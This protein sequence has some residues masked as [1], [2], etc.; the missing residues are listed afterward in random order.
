MAQSVTASIIEDFRRARFKADLQNILSRLTGQNNELLVYD[1][2]RQKLRGVETATRRHEAI[3]LDAIVGSVG[4]YGDYNRMFLP[5]KDSDADR[6]V[7]VKQAVTGLAGVPPIEVYKIGEAY[8]VKDGNHRVSVAR[9]LG[10]KT[11]DAY[12][13]DVQTDVPFSLH[14]TPDD[15]ITK[16]EYADFLE[17]TG[18]NKLRPEA[19]LSVTVPG[20]Y[21]TLL[22]H[23]QVHHYFM[24]LEA[25]RDVSYEEAV[26]HWYDTVYRPIAQ[27][28]EQ[29][30]LL[31]DFPHRTATDLYLWLAEHQAELERELG[32]QLSPAKVTQGVSEVRQR[33]PRETRLQELSPEKYLLDSVLVAIN[34]TEGGWRAL[35]QAF[36]LARREPLRLYGLHVVAHEGELPAAAEVQAEF[37]RR[38]QQAGVSAQF[39]TEVG[40]VTSA[41]GARARWTDL[42]VASLSYPP[43]KTDWLSSG[44]NQLLRRSPRPVL[45]VPGSVTEANHALLGYNGSGK[46]DIALFAAAYLAACWRIKLSVLTVDERDKQGRAM[47]DRARGYLE[48][49]GVEATYLYREG[50]V[51]ATV[52]AAAGELG[53]DVLLLGSYQYPPLLEPLLGGVLDEILRQSRLPMLI[54]Q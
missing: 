40:Q 32:W 7:K 21:E 28:L 10:V 3:P 24:G 42:V 15:L 20:Q 2:V 34:G 18:L 51:A 13:T 41:I 12:V 37:E 11:I 48:S 8:F 43:S 31:Q 35:E 38:A 39:A 30:G 53:A 29:R 9:Q 19:D 23:I 54:C 26:A 46:S 45:A 36:V 1:E 25:K 16:A 4:R 52:L 17:R 47:L 33:R 6:W 5:L 14:D 22:E 49:R 50:P 44:F 27:L